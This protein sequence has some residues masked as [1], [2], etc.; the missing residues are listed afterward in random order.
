MAN[1]IKAIPCIVC[2]LKCSV[3]DGCMDELRGPVAQMAGQAIMGGIAARPLLLRFQQ[4]RA[5][6]SQ[7]GAVLMAA[8]RREAPGAAA[9]R[10][11]I[12][13]ASQPLHP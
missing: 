3:V 1:A 5:R 8:M 7:A 11:A 12:G 2:C 10:A 4:H 6:H 9:G 13:V